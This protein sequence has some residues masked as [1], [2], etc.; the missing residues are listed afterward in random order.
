[1]HFK[2]GFTLIELSIVLVI[3]G[4]LAGGV[5]VGRDLIHQAELRGDVG[6]LDK[7]N[8]GVMT[9]RN[10][11]NCMPGDCFNAANFFSFA[12]I[13]NGNGNSR[14][15]S[16]Y[17]GDGC[18]AGESSTNGRYNGT[19][20]A[21]A[22]AQL[23][24]ANLASY[25]VFDPTSATLNIA[26]VTPRL[27]TGGNFMLRPECTYN[28]TS[29]QCMTNGRHTYRLGV[30]D[31]NNQSI[32][33]TM[34]EYD[35]DNDYAI[36]YYTPLDAYSLDAKLDDGNAASGTVTAAWSSGSMPTGCGGGTFLPIAFFFTEA[37]CA[38]N[39]EGYGLDANCNYLHQM[40]FR[41]VSLEIRASF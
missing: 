24:A 28:G 7:I 16:N 20:V 19:E 33:K 1:M 30:F 37:P 22:H 3:V 2:L 35:A 27:K 32:A 10:K 34:N 13:T 41:T 5:L 14:I 8:A 23:A 25:G 6:A 21:Q 39:G 4:L 38:S 15:E 18:D 17:A 9:F 11:Y 29:D 12:G 40:N 36:N 26:Q 31:R